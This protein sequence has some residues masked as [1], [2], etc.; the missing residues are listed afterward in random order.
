MSKPSLG[1][2][3]SKAR[4]VLNST[5]SAITDLAESVAAQRYVYFHKKEALRAVGNIERYNA[6]KLTP[7]L[8]RRADDYG[9]DP[10]RDV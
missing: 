1:Q 6:A 4:L 2:L 3:K 10:Q 9:D 8:R 7:A 5:E